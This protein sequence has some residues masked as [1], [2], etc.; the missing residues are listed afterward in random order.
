MDFDDANV[1]AVVKQQLNGNTDAMNLTTEEFVFIHIL[2]REECSHRKD[3]GQ[4]KTYQTK[5]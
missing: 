1:V 3:H 5:G 2:A 4:S